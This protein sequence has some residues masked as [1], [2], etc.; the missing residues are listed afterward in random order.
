MRTSNQT[1]GGSTVRL[2]LQQELSRMSTLNTLALSLI[3]QLLL[4]A[5]DQEQGARGARRMLRGAHIG[6]KVLVVRS[7]WR[8][9]S[10]R[11]A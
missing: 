7:D 9:R 8:R 4:R 1:S 10:G 2:P 5:R 11:S 3:L 6:E